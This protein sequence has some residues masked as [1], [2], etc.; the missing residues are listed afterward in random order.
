MFEG[1]LKKILNHPEKVDLEEIAFLLSDSRV[2]EKL[3]ALADEVRQ[4]Y[5]G[6]DV[7][8]RGII[9]FS[10]YC[11][12]DCLYCGIRASNRNVKRYRMKADEIIHRARVIYQM[13]VKTIVLQSGE[14]LFYDEESIAYVIKEI[15]KMKVAV[16]LS[17]GER[18]YEE[19][20]Y[21]KESG[22]DRYLMRHETADE[23]IYEKMHPGDSLQ[24]RIEHLRKLKQLGYEIG[25]GSMVG[26]PGQNDYS[27]A[28]DVLF[29]YELD[30]DM[31]GIGPF[32][33]H[34]NTPL[35][36]FKGGDL[37]K[38]LKL[39]ALT[40]LFLPDS[41]IPATTALGTIHPSGRQLALKCGANVIMPNFTPS[42]YRTQY[43][44]Y[45]GKICIF[46]KDTACG[47]CTKQLIKSAGYFVSNS[48]GYRKKIA[49][50]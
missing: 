7:Y 46:E 45:P 25:A 38:T 20:R 11:R 19:Y 36:N 3:F 1:V 48:L 24:N 5:M 43:V 4:K 31:V 2:D 41:N 26:L 28:K 35:S 49:T 13:G 12:N 47:E 29:V 33:P 44:L 9:E 32:I 27:L 39:I 30:A 23:Q 8:L 6:K 21:W 16:T 50:E 40:R 42:P 17:I 37:Q 34:P 18:T 22:A 14:D 10:N 15:K